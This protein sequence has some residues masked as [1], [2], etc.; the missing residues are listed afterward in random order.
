M[1][2]SQEGFV[3]SDPLIRE[4]LVRDGIPESSSRKARKTL[5]SRELASFLAA[6]VVEEASELA[7]QILHVAEGGVSDGVLLEMADLLEVLDRVRSVFSLSVTQVEETRREKFRIRG[8]F[9]TD[10]VLPVPAPIRRLAN[11]TDV[12]LRSSLLVELAR[13][14]RADLAVAFIREGAA[15][16]LLPALREALS[17]GARIR[18][19]TTDYLGVTDPEA[20]DLLMSL[21][22]KGQVGQIE[23]RCFLSAPSGEVFRGY[24]PKAYLFERENGRRIAFVGSSNLSNAALAGNVEWNVFLRETDLA[25]PV[26]QLSREFGRIFASSRSVPV[27][28]EFVRS[29]RERRKTPSWGPGLSGIAGEVPSPC[30]T[31]LQNEVLLSLAEL[32]AD[33]AGRALAILA[34]GLGKTYLAAFDC[35]GFSR[36]L[37]LAHRREILEQARETFLRVHPEKRASFVGEGEAD[38]SGDLVFAQVQTLARLSR[39]LEIPPE[40]FDYIVVDECHHAEAPSYQ[41]ILVHFRPKFVLGLTAPPYRMDNGDIF[42]LMDGHVVCRRTFIEGIREGMLVPFHYFGIKDTVDYEEIPWRGSRYDPESLERALTESRR[43]QETLRAF[44]EHEGSKT[45]AFCVSRL[46]ARLLAEF[47]SREG[48]AAGYLTGETPSGERQA[49]LRKFREGALAILFV[50]DL[51]NEG[52]DIPEIDR[53]MLL[54]P[55]DSP[56]VFLQQIGRGL[57]LASGKSHLTILDF[58]GNHRRAHYVLPALTGRE[59]K[60]GNWAEEAGS[61]LRQYKQER[62]DLPPGVTVTFDWEAIDLLEARILSSEPRETALLS[63]YAA[64]W[65]TLG[66]R[67]TLVEMSLECE[68][69]PREALQFFGS[70]QKMLENLEKRRPDLIILRE[71]ER[72]LFSVAGDFFREV[73][74]TPMTRSYKMVVLSVW[75]KREGGLSRPISLRDLSAGFRAFFADPLYSKDLKGTE[76]S[77]LDHVTDRTLESYVQRNPVSAWAGKSRKGEGECFFLYDKSSRTLSFLGTGADLPGFREALQERVS[78]RLSDYFQRRVGV[79]SPRNPD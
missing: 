72:Q 79:G 3:G 45:V 53:V 19:L 12:P 29:Y 61:I 67:P 78:Y 36:V 37:F 57:R 34:T 70:W 16:S 66:H 77:D 48:V 21:E 6:K 76:I 42:A 55:T 59:P 18:I 25:D 62:L 8:G 1:A 75:L 69:H 68:V 51:L 20:L 44:R 65:E 63:S 49:T 52:V 31:P 26:D 10:R 2:E 33:G 15:A 71:D 58:I 7:E 28:P 47:F 50:V 43:A 11:G 9:E 39:L 32:R 41:R 46:H 56:T 30:P 27:N 17:R 13:C 5:D 22:K 24:H 64:L 60:N 73:E 54:R 74:R 38:V 35:R 4:K 14:R 23:I 40:T